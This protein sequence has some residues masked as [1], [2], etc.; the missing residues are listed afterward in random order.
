[1]AYTLSDAGRI[2]RFAKSRVLNDGGAVI[3]ILTVAVESDPHGISGNGGQLEPMPLARVNGEW[4]ALVHHVM[5]P[6]VIRV[7]PALESS[8]FEGSAELVARIEA[9]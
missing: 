7:K 5:G 9:R 3:A 8:S 6:D 1:M 2:G 4:D